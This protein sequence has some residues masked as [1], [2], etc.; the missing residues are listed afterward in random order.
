MTLT[1]T[2]NEI[3][4][5]A[6]EFDNGTQKIETYMRDVLIWSG[7]AFPEMATIRCSISGFRIAALD[8]RELEDM[9][10]AACANLGLARFNDWMA[11]FTQKD[12]AEAIES[13]IDHMSIRTLQLARPAPSLSYSKGS[14]ILSS[15]SKVRQTATLLNSLIWDAGMFRNSWAGEEDL[16]TRLRAQAFIADGL[17]ELSR[18]YTDG[19]ADTLLDELHAGLVE[20]DAKYLISKLKFT[21]KEMKRVNEIREAVEIKQIIDLTT[22]LV[23]DMIVYRD[24]TLDI[25]IQPQR[26]TQRVYSDNTFNA[27][28]KP[29]NSNILQTAKPEK[30]GPASNRQKKPQTPEELAKAAQKNL[31][32]SLLANAFAPAKE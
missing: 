1:F 6:P 27:I 7:Y 3:E 32:K 17:V 22:Q 10:L 4:Y 30:T 19:I 21:N 26:W 29:E 15:L 8:T 5:T 2:V 23:V 16:V 25:E 18:V 12:V 13:V 11:S 20:L 24:T 9:I 28:Q 14:P 31:F